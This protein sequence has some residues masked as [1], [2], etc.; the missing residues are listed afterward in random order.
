MKQDVEVIDKKHY[1]LQVHALYSILINVLIA[2]L[3]N[4]LLW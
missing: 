3:H 4:I 1:T 2:G